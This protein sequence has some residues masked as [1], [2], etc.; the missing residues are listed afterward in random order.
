[1]LELEEGNKNKD[2]H[3]HGPDEGDDHA[4]LAPCA[5]D[6]FSEKIQRAIF[7]GGAAVLAFQTRVP[8]LIHI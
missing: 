8:I 5:L 7:S 3:D 1:M 6:Q 2:G 4:D